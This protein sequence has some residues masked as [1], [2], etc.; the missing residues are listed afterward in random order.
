MDDEIKEEEP[1]QHKQQLFF[2]YLQ[3]KGDGDELN[4]SRVGGGARPL[5]DE[6]L[7]HHHEAPRLLAQRA[8]RVVLQEGEQL[9]SDLGQNSGHVVSGQGVGVVQVHHGVLQVA[10]HTDGVSNGGRLQP[11]EHLDGLPPPSPD[12]EL[13]TGREVGGELLDQRQQHRLAEGAGVLPEHLLGLDGLAHV[14][15]QVQVCGR[16]RLDRESHTSPRSGGLLPVL[17]VHRGTVQSC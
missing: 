12:L 3:H 16:E 17:P 15:H 9:L 4:V 5:I 7:Q 2:K 13:R 11:G 1:K 6:A 10:A 8:V 14:Q